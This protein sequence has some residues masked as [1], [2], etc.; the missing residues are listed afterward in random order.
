MTEVRDG[1]GGGGGGL[2]MLVLLIR[3]SFRGGGVACLQVPL[4]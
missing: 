3:G 4:Q 2:S 1:G